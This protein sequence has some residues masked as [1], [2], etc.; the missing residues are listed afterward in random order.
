L[1][2]TPPPT[3]RRSVPRAVPPETKA[4]LV[5]RWPWARVSLQREIAARLGLRDFYDSIARNLSDA[6][7]FDVT[8]PQTSAENGIDPDEGLAIFTVREDPEALLVAVGI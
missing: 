6:V 8:S 2:T 5:G 1:A 3:R 7:G 4:A